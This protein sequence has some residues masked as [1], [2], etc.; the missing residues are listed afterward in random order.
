MSSSLLQSYPQLALI[1]NV[2]L[3]GLGGYCFAT[4]TPMW[5]IGLLAPLMRKYCPDGFTL[6]EFLRRRYGWMLGVLSAMIFI[7]FMF[8]F[9]IVELNTY[10]VVVQTIAPG[11]SR[12]VPPLIV[13]ITTFLY[14][15]YGGFKA[16]LWTDNF[17]TIVVVVFIIIGGVMFGKRL[18]ISKD[19]M[20]ESQLLGATAYAGEVWYILTIS[21]IPAQ[22]FNQ[23]FWQRAFA[24]KTNTTL[25]IAVIGATLPLFAICFLVGMAGPLAQWA[26]IQ[27]PIG[28]S[29]ED[30]G[31]NALFKALVHMPL[32]VHGIVLVLSGVLSCSAYDTF[33][34]AMISVI[35]SDLFLSRVNLWLCRAFLFVLNVP[36][37]ALASISIDIFEV[38][39]IADL[40]GLCVVP[41]VFL[42]LIPGFDVYNGLDVFI[43]GCGGFLTVFVFGTI[44]Y[45]GDAIAGGTLISLPNGLYGDPSDYSV[46][47]AF[48]A[49]PLG[50]IG[51]AL[52]SCGCRILIGY[53]YARYTGKPFTMLDKKHAPLSEYV[54]DEDRP[55]SFFAKVRNLEDGHRLDPKDESNQLPN[56]DFATFL[57]K[58][59]HDTA[60]EVFDD[61]LSKEVQAEA[62]A[63]GPAGAMHGAPAVV[64]HDDDVQGTWGTHDPHQGVR[65]AT[66]ASDPTKH[67]TMGAASSPYATV[68]DAVPETA[69]FSGLAPPT[70]HGDGPVTYAPSAPAPAQRRFGEA[71]PPEVVS[72]PPRV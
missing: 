62:D 47:G 48:L 37:V 28:D 15:S 2:G 7:G 5:A 57:H 13:A 4:V 56:Y 19:L 12:I 24:S 26:G 68:T 27:A 64:Q 14:T 30:D 69:T 46:V 20:H 43:G 58:R 67:G 66:W 35:E 23:G 53:C 59:P 61:N 1:P 52:A 6:S 32:W 18:P 34:S 21:I 9:M 55:E 51:F 41:A 11:T 70:T 40:G 17:N 39:L 36:C 72:V 33:Q 65:D 44:Y 45:H 49:A 50:N 63:W 16:S 22:M 54:R 3:F 60:S 29:S 8:C 25:Y 38:F 42:G 10:G 71:P 31:S